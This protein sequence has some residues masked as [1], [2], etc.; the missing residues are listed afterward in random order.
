MEVQTVFYAA[1]PVVGVIVWFVRLE[2]RVNT[3]DA[4]MKEF[5][6]DLAYIRQRIDRAIN[7]G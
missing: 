5:R 1:I 6:E 4:I 7:W 3:Q 2:G